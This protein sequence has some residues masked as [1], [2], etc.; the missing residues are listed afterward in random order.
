MQLNRGQ[1]S[2]NGREREVKTEGF[3]AGKSAED[4]VLEEV[5]KL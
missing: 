5:N 2:G 4:R 1:D 3:G